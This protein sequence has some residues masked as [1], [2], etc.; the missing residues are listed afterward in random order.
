M[1]KVLS[2]F[3]IPMISVSFLACSNPVSEPELPVLN[4]RGVTQ[5]RD[6]KRNTIFR[7]SVEASPASAKVIKVRY[8]TQEETARSGKDF[9]AVSGTLVIPAGQSSSEIEVTVLPDSLRQADQMFFLELT[10]P[11]NAKTGELVKAPGIIIN[12]GTWFPVDGEGYVA[13]LAYS[14]LSLVWS[15]EFNGKLLNPAA[16]VYETGGTGWGNN[17]LQNYTTSE[18]NSFLSGG[19]LVIEARK[20]QSG[21][22]AYTS[23]RIISKDKKTF[24]YGRMDIRAKLPQGKGI[25]PA[26]WML[27][28]NISQLGWPACGEID[29]MEYLGHET[30]KVYGTLHWGLKW[31][32]HIYK[33][34]NTTLPSGHFYEQFH[35]FSLSWTADKLTILL[36][37]VPYFSLRK[38][39]ITGGDYPFDKPHFF[40]MNV[41]VGGNWPGNPDNSTQFPQRMIVDYIRVY[42]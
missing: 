23:A 4:L 10:A 6:S 11:E 33:G 7:F 3:L 16:W 34:G 24:T 40:I 2:L 25:W 12:D 39:G 15:E 32:S 5:A 35:L 9:I 37:D 30:N 13:P 26:L 21:S 36:D 38:D 1:K 22:N 41:A 8:Q 27:G 42:Q 28:N 19:Y 17:E 29:I 31:D 14:G 20:E 18:K